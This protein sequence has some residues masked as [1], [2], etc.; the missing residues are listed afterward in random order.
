MRAP[1]WCK[2]VSQ[3]ISAD[4]PGMQSTHLAACIP[5]T[6]VLAADAPPLGAVAREVGAVVLVIRAEPGGVAAALMPADAVRVPPAPMPQ[7]IQAT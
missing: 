3:Q 6:L 1:Y 5:H 2:H 7:P 4:R